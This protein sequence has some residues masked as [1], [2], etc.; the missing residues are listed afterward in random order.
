MAHN[1]HPN[2]LKNLKPLLTSENAREFQ[3]KGAAAKRAN[4]LA[5]EQLKLTV[6][7]FKGFKESFEENPVGAI[8]ILRILMVKALDEGDNVQAADLAKS[9]AEFESPKLSRIDQ[10]NTELTVDELS[11]EELERK[12]LDATRNM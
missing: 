10:T 1:I 3:L 6:K 12:L 4:T 5:R 9:L 7:Q 11:D 8:D 2:S